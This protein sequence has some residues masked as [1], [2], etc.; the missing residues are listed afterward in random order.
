MI[1]VQFFPPRFFF[2]GRRVHHGLVALLWLL[3]DIHDRHVWISDFL[4]HPDSR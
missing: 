1:R 3:T 2:C 4:K